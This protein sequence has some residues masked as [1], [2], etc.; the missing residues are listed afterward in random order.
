[1]SLLSEDG[2]LATHAQQCNDMY[3]LHGRQPL[4]LP[5]PPP[6]P[7]T[8]SSS[9][10]DVMIAW[11]LSLSALLLLA[12]ATVAYYCILLQVPSCPP[13]PPPAFTRE[14]CQVSAT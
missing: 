9:G 3:E 13:L 5:S 12:M 8:E 4:P 14:L 6:L 7:E 2:T 11:T 1:M 10:P